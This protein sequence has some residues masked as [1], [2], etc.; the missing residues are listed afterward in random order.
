MNI[1]ELYNLFLKS[2]GIATDSRIDLQSKIFFALKGENFDANKFALQA[3]EKGAYY[4]VADDPSLA[5][6]P[7]IIQVNDSL[8]CLQELAAY[9]RKQLNIPIIAITGSNG[10]TTTK[11]LI[12]RVL[13][14]KY[15]VFS[16]PGNFNNHIGVPLSLLQINSSHQIAVLEIGANHIGENEFLTRMVQPSHGIT[17][18]IGKDHLGEFGG[19]EGVIKA[20]KEFTDYFAEHTDKVFFLNADDPIL[21]KLVPSANI[22][23]GIKNQEAKYVGSPDHTSFELKALIN[24][25]YQLSSHLFGAFNLY[26]IMAAFAIGDYFKVPNQLINEAISSYIPKNN[27]SQIINWQSNKIIF[28]AYNANPSSMS[29]ALNAFAELEHPKKMVILGSMAELGEYAHNEHLQIVKFLEKHP[30]NTV[31]LL[32]K[33][34]KSFEKYEFVTHFDHAKTLNK[35][36]QNQ[37]INNSLILVKGSRSEKLE[38]AFSGLVNLT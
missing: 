29:E 12:Y 1:P 21:C 7:K 6:N 19:F 30:F 20:Y 5:K 17:T 15:T 3:I 25:K 8:V 26:N 9:H 14:T 28:D 24:N 23:F 13:D 33:H 16:T 35:W 32:G 27:R 38:T 18:N 34:F 31:I 37:N 2:K 22:S 4:V 36:L 11:E 10:K